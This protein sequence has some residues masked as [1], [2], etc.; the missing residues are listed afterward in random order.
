MDT[1]GQI[2]QCSLCGYTM[3]WDALSNSFYIFFAHLQKLCVCLSDQI[4]R[5]VRSAMAIMNI[6]RDFCHDGRN[7]IWATT[8]KREREA[9]IYPQYLLS[10][11]PNELLSVGKRFF[12]DAFFLSFYWIFADTEL[13]WRKTAIVKENS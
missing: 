11:C 12:S 5:S 4:I 2:S 9:A 13:K 6:P 1:V 10:S 8:M 7:Y 3:H